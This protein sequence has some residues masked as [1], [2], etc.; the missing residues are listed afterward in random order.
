MSLITDLKTL[1]APYLGTFNLLNQP[2]IAYEN[3]N[4]SRDITGILCLLP[5]ISTTPPTK[6]LGGA[7]FF[8]DRLVIRLINYS[9]TPSLKLKNCLEALYSQYDVIDQV[10]TPGDKQIFEQ[11]K[12]VIKIYDLIEY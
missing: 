4:Y 8:E 6:L 7:N 9:T 11:V 2:S 10:Y 1:L 5:Y 12:A 3:S